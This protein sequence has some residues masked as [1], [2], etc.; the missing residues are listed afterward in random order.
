[1]H[2]HG[3]YLLM[4]CPADKVALDIAL[5]NCT[6]RHQVQAAEAHPAYNSLAKPFFTN[7]HNSAQALLDLTALHSGR[8][9]G[10]AA[11]AAHDSK[12]RST[13]TPFI[14]L[15]TMTPIRVFSRNADRAEIA[16]P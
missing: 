12:M 5:V 7:G 6:T 13:T 2:A 10:R 11:R 15:F 4:S 1:M 14:S 16:D 8:L 9:P 3:R